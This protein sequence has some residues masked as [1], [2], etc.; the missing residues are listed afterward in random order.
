MTLPTLLATTFWIPSMTSGSNGEVTPEFPESEVSGK[1]TSPRIAG[2]LDS[3]ALPPEPPHPASSIMADA[4]NAPATVG[5]IEPDV[6]PAKRLL[7]AFNATPILTGTSSH[8]RS[9][10]AKTIAD[11]DGAPP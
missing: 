8:H 9:I 5:L 4:M 11:Q 7:L 10:P 6:R 2:A 1:A 3:A